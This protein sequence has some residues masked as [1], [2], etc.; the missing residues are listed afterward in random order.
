MLKHARWF[1]IVVLTLS[2]G[3]VAGKFSNRWGKPVDLVAAGRRID[4]VPT[5]LGSERLGYWEM[6]GSAEPIEADAAE[7]LECTGSTVRTYRNVKSGAAVQMVLLVGP[8]GPMSV[9][10]PDVCFKGA[11]YELLGPQRQVTIASRRG[12]AARLWAGS[13]RSNGLQAEGLRVV[14]AWN[15]GAGWDAP[16]YPRLAY[17]RTA[18]LY[19]LMVV[20]NVS[21]G[22]AEEETDKIWYE[23]LNE[24]IPEIDAIIHKESAT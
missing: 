19:K 2:T 17:A 15:D 10:T 6:I 9:H 1:L 20:T 8:P 23:F 3:L 14:Y 21:D 5:R 4:Q 22:A 24:L 16:T 11:N 7:M 18:L 12:P 13:F